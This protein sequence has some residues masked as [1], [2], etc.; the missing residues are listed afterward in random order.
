MTRPT[1]RA[2]PALSRRRLVGGA[3]AL[4][5]GGLLA[6][7][8]EE[9]G[10][11]PAPSTGTESAT[12]TPNTTEE[13]LTAFVTAVNDQLTEADE[14][15][16]AELLAPRVVG[17]A[18]TFREDL[19]ELIG[20]AENEEDFEDNWNQEFSRPGPTLYTALTSTSAE[21]PRVAIALSTPE[22]AEGED[23]T[24]FSFLALRQE[25]A[26]SP[27]TTWGWAQQM[28]GVEIPEKLPNA[29]TGSE[30]VGL[31]AEGLLMTPKDALA[32]Y[33][34]VL[35]DGNGPD[36]E[37][38]LAP[39]PYQDTVHDQIQAER[40]SL[41]EDVEE[42]VA[43]TVKEVYEVVEDDLL[44]LRLED[45]GA[46]VMSTF[47]STRTLTI[48]ADATLSYD[49]ENPI[50]DV[51]GTRELTDELVRTYGTTVA[52]YIPAEGSDAQIQPIAATRII[53][54]VEGS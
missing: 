20:R 48:R 11:P 38:Q 3:G 30:P 9:P 15:R 43:P 24:V 49:E 44:G 37:D 1:P 2:L 17:S 40:A 10:T 32:L 54:G 13:Q 12:P 19:Y 50:T 21:F 53:T 35:S 52:L 45:G 33:A 26:R 22:V 42:D 28:D 25:D 4:L 34:K 51:L 16:D 14:E 6:A 41:N 29:L 7:C 8:A 18:A 31:E 5:A 39:N 46:I 47:T 23:S 36:S 27:Y